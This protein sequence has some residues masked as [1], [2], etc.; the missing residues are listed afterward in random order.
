MKS[1]SNLDKQLAETKAAMR[2]ES[3][4]EV[5][6]QQE[7]LIHTLRELGVGRDA[8]AVGDRAPG[9]YLPDQVGA[10]VTLADL[11]KLGSVV[12]SFFRGAWC[13]FCETELKALHM[14]LPQIEQ[15]GA[16]LVAISPQVIE[17]SM[18]MAERLLL[19]YSILSDE[20]NAAAQE[21]GL[22]FE[23][24]EEFREFR[25]FHDGMVNLEE[26]NADLRYLLPIP[27]TYVIDRSGIVRSSYVD[28]DYTGR[29]DLAEVLD[30]LDEIG[31]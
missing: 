29:A 31:P 14:A 30:A 24:P 5:V 6:D 18:T 17:K 26:F 19:D 11:L 27:A 8:I 15:R 2:R 9:F 22:A 7:A 3:G 12:L 25:E 13:P 10:P 28:P 23:I 16:R 4:D 21:Y 20:G 1:V